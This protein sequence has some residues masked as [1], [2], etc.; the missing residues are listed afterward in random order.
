MAN[1]LFPDVVIEKRFESILNTKLDLQRFLSVD[2]EL[3]EKSGMKKT[4]VKKTVSGSVEDLGMGEGNTGYIEVGTS[5]ADYEV[6]T[7]QGRFAYYDEEAMKDDKVVEAGLAGLAETMVNDF[8]NKAVAEWEK[9]SLV[10]FGAQWTFDNIVDAIAMMNLEGEEGLFMLINPA[11]QAA[12]RK[13]LKDDLKY[14]EAFVRSGYIGSVC[15]VPVYVSKAIPAGEAVLAHKAAVTLFVKKG[16]E[17]EHDRIANT[18]QSIEYIRKV[19][20]VALTDARK[21]VMLTAGADPTTGYT[22]LAEQPEG[23]STYS[24]FYELDG[25]GINAEMKQLE[26][27][28]TFVPNKFYSKD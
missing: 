13:N 21:V 2:Y 27:A 10:K 17:R 5:T 7:T 9:A 6:G 23:W 20:L 12:F 26:A 19:A 18:R 24:D 8:N 14:V 16:V 22:L 25:V 15:G 11:Q 3:A 4:I 28:T 1:V